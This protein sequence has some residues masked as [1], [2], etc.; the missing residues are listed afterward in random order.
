[1]AYF[2]LTAEVLTFH[3]SALI[4]NNLYIPFEADGE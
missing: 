4:H 2:Q 3:I 1:M